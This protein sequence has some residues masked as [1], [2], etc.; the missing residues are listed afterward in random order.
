MR[1]NKEAIQVVIR[2]R[3]LLEPFEDE[4]I[5]AVNDKRTSIYTTKSLRDI[6]T[7]RTRKDFRRRY[8]EN[9]SP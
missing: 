4:E 9:I 7:P 6:E 1:P 2:M 8:A 3:P 5:W